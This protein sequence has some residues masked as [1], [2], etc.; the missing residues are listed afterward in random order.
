MN[1][2]PE[3]F[4]LLLVFDAVTAIIAAA[5]LLE[6]LPLAALTIMATL[7]GANVFLL[8]GILRSTNT[9]SLTKTVDRGRSYLWI[10]G[11]FLAAGALVQAALLVRDGFSWPGAGRM[12]AG[13]ILGPLFLFVAKKSA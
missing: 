11:F 1:S 8:P 3:K 9:K 13:F 10:W 5:L 4:I 12:I 7:F 6:H 2:L